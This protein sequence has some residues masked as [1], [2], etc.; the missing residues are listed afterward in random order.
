MTTAAVA[1]SRA[2][3]QFAV[4]EQTYPGWHI[5]RFTRS[6][7]T[8]GGWWATRRVSLLPSHRSAGLVPSIARWDALS[9]SSELAAQDALGQRIGYTVAS[10]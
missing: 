1:G 3:A 8:F 2:D 5:T 7:G 9:L 4:L 10:P 6:D